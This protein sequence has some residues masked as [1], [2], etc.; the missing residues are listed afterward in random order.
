MPS[1]SG[2]VI[3]LVMISVP[4]FLHDWKG[5]RES[6]AKDEMVCVCDWGR[7]IP[8]DLPCNGYTSTPETH[9]KPLIHLP[10]KQ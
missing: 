9:K 5:A 3:D 1:K 7:H 8:T 10:F 2:V 4:I 6:Q